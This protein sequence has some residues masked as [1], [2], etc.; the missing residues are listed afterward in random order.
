MDTQ[1][2]QLVQWE[3]GDASQQCW[4][5]ASA[6]ASPETAFLPADFAPE[7]LACAPD[8]AACWPRLLAWAT[9]PGSFA[10]ATETVGQNIDVATLAVA[11]TST[12]RT[13]RSQKPMNFMSN[14]R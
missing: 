10:F 1:E 14:A 13:T 8:S 4:A 7:S 3:Q 6:S 5:W 11:G 9:C 2:P 12:A